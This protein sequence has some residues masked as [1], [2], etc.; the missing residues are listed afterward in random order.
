MNV[1]RPSTSWRFLASANAS[2][3]FVVT[4][5]RLVGVR[6]T[7]DFGAVFLFP[8]S[9]PPSWRRSRQLA[10]SRL[11]LFPCRRGQLTLRPVRPAPTPQAVSPCRSDGAARLRPCLRARPEHGDGEDPQRPLRFTHLYQWS[12]ANMSALWRRSPR[13]W[14]PSPQHNPPD[15]DAGRPRSRCHSD[16]SPSPPNVSCEHSG[17]RLI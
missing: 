15:S 11:R 10:H 7:R 14:P 6:L 8:H 17:K 3:N 2:R 12:E 9:P 4:G 13:P 1:M 16:P 5:R